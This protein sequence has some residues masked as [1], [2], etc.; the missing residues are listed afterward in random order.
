MSLFAYII[1]A[2]A[3]ALNILIA[4]RPCAERFP[5]RLT[6]GLVLSLLVAVVYAGFLWLGISLGNIIRYDSPIEEGL[7]DDVNQ[8]VF[9]GLI[10][11]VAVKIMFPVLRKKHQEVPIFDISRW[12]IVLL[13]AIATGVNAFLIGLAFG[14]VQSIEG[15]FWKATV[16]MMVTVFLLAYLAIMMG[17]QKKTLKER[18]WTLLSALML[19]VAIFFQL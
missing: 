13:L 12:G 1:I 3:L 8:L 15:Q 10:I 16:P 14:F 17:R 4:L 18:R 5:I 9:I 6:R 7:Y 19:L 11:L 2:I